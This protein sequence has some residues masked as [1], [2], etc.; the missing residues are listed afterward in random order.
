MFNGFNKKYTSSYIYFS[1]SAYRVIVDS[2]SVGIHSTYISA[3]IPE[4]RK[5]DNLLS[6]IFLRKSFN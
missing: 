3:Y 1:Y 5:T 4:F 6:T 2:N